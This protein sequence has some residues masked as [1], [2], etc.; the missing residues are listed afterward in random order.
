VRA[1]P[2]VLADPA[3]LVQVDALGDG[4]VQ[5]A[6]K[7]WVGVADFGVVESE[8]AQAILD[9]LR[10]RG[11]AIAPARSLRLVNAER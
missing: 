3:P 2:R 5:L 4:A 9:A 11:V 7:P 1:N 6:V 8:L 10:Q